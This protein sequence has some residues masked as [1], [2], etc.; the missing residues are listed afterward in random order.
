MRHGRVPCPSCPLPAGSRPP[1]T[2]ESLSGLEKLFVGE[3][4]PL[5]FPGKAE[6]ISGPP[7][8]TRERACRACPSPG[9]G[10]GKL[11]QEELH[12]PEGDEVGAVAEGLFRQ[13]WV[14]RKRASTRRQEQPWPGEMNLRS[15]PLALPAAPGIWTLWVPSKTTDTRR[16]A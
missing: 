5:P 10:L 11:L 6:H 7:P 9:H 13:G 14:S 12:L 8:P 1:R 3:A 2:G 15:P 4:S 16:S